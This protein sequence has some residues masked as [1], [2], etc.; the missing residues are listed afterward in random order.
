MVHSFLMN[1]LIVGESIPLID[2]QLHV[3]FEEH[4]DREFHRLG[5]AVAM[6]DALAHCQQC[7]MFSPKKGLLIRQPKWLK[8]SNAADLD[9]LNKLL[10]LAQ[11]HDVVLVIVAKSIDKRSSVYKRLKA[12]SL[13]ETNA[14]PFK[15]W[16]TQK[17]LD[18]MMSYCRNHD[19][20]IEP[21]AAKLLV[22]AYGTQVGI[23]KQELTKCMATIFPKTA[24]TMA[25][26]QATSSHALGHYTQLSDAV[27]GGNAQGICTAI[28]ALLAIKE[29]A[30]K[31]VS[32]LVFQVNQGLPLVLGLANNM[33]PD[34]VATA[35]NKHPYFVKKQMAAF[36]NN[37]LRSK[38]TTLVGWLCTM[39]ERIKTGKLTAK[40]SLIWF[41]NCLKYQ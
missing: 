37:P 15:E 35:L 5:D 28:H 4:H 17:I 25:D 29:D 8:T 34:T 31:I 9:M 18:W 19:V 6:S 10:D 41:S 2:D 23:M 24:I 38:W 33:L 20:T 3:I 12:F 36:R 14:A 7:D 22:N 1:H 32:Q 21:S 27:K 13:S 40:Q 16:E 30:Y 11:M 39:D 26:M